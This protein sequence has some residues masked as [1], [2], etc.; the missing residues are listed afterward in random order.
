[1]NLP[2]RLARAVFLPKP[3][4]VFPCVVAV[5]ALS[6]T[7]VLA[8]D[9]TWDNSASAGVQSTAGTWNNQSNS[10]WTADGGT[11]NVQWNNANLDNAIF[12]TT[13]SA[14][15]VTLASVAANNVTITGGGAARLTLST[16]TLTFGGTLNVESGNTVTIAS[17]LSGAGAIVNNGDLTFNNA[18]NNFTGGV[19]LNAGSSTSISGS[20]FSGVLGT[21]TLTLNGGTITSFNLFGTGTSLANAV[22]FG[23]DL[24]FTTFSSG[25]IGGTVDLGGATRT[26]SV[27]SGIAA[28]FSGVISNG[29]IIAAG[30]KGISLSNVNN[31]F[32]SGVTV[33]AGSA[34]AYSGNSYSG[35]AGNVTAGTLGTGVLTL[36]NGSTF[37]TSG[38]AKSGNNIVIKGDV[39]FATNNMTFEG[40]VDLN[41][42]TR[43]LT[44]TNANGLTFSGK[45]SNG[46]LV[47]AGSAGSVTLT[48][49]ESDFAG[50]VTLNAG[51]S[52]AFQGTSTGTAGNVTKG[53]LGTGTFT[54]N[55]GSISTSYA[56]SG[57]NIY[58]NVVIGG[59]F[60][61][62]PDAASYFYGNWALGSAI[63]TV[64]VNAAYASKT[65]LLQNV[66]SGDGGFYFTNS[67]NGA[68]TST[69]RFLGSQA[70]T[71]TGLTTLA[72]VTTVNGGV[73]VL[74][75]N[76][77]AGVTS[78][79]GDL[80]VTGGTVNLNNNNQIANT[81]AVTIN[82][83]GAV[84][85]LGANRTDTVGT[86]TLD[87]GGSITGT[88]TS[89]LTSTGTFEMKSGSVTAI[90]AGSGIALNKTTAGT[91]TLSGANTF[92]G[93]T[94]VDAGTL[95]LGSTG[96]LAS[97]SYSI[98]S[99]ATFDASAKTSYSLAAVGT[100]IGIGAT[101]SG[102]FNGPTGA[103]TI[104]NSLTLNFST[105]LIADGQTYNLFDFGSK[106][107]DFSSVGLTGSI[108]GSLLL[109]GTDT[110]TGL[111]G[112]YSFTFNQ[113]TGNLLVTTSAVPEPSTYALLLGGMAMTAVLIQR[114]RR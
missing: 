92:T 34:L 73:A 69:V 7:P 15:T 1:M 26:I 31:T 81:S 23:G 50:G 93:A 46:G 32:A 61:I 16:S 72:G 48:S 96:S 87:G 47:I 110:W 43:T 79:A 18:T 25:S 100:T 86:V 42:G 95:A 22:V 44:K 66:V 57:A 82:G 12:T 11:S 37:T 41:N 90:L 105:S 88:G 99:G 113:A 8:A 17:Q 10:N 52:L 13:G 24:A 104:G 58:N 94:T 98:A 27:G 89:A 39:S 33:S 62:T 67:S 112:G 21:G 40:A 97:T 76:K 84:F 101:T 54:I 114:R 71:Y 56:G 103:L 85:A 5:A 38:T 80:L 70:N 9:L 36:E 3:F 74:D 51:V 29:G 6:A 64:N 83:S 77:S 108:V 78:I 60:S 59:D 53:P 14:Y 2:H 91:V 102:F 4:V 106:T 109:T 65:L 30:I 68:Y 75:L 55:G 20:G 28:S 107:G 45:I 63:R 49:T 19:T 35:T 111:A